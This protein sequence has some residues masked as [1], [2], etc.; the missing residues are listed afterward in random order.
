ML[1]VNCQFS[2][3]IGV[4]CSWLAFLHG[5]QAVARSSRA[6]PTKKLSEMAA[7]FCLLIDLGVPATPSGFP[8]YLCSLNPHPH[9]LPNPAPKS[10]SRPRTR[11]QIP[12]AK[13]AAPIPN[14]FWGTGNGNGNGESCKDASMQHAITRI[15]TSQNKVK[16]RQCNML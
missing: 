7:F 11:S 4:W 14:A 1:I 5:V 10:R 12:L 2:I 15:D 8:L 6:T 16:A 13:D 9:P 3:F